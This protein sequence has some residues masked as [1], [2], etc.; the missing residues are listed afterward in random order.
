MLARL[1]SP[2]R[3]EQRDTVSLSQ[4]AHLWGPN[5][6]YGYTPVTVSTQSALGHAASSACIDVLATSVS[7]LPVDAVRIVGSIRRPVSPPPQLVTQ[8]SVLVELDSWLYQLVDSMLTDGNGFGLVVATDLAQRPTQIELLAP[9]TVTERELVKGVPQAKVDSDTHK[10]YPYGD[11]WHVPGKFVRAGSPFAES[12]LRR[13][14]ATIGAAIAA[15]DYGSRWFGD[16]GHPSGLIYSE[17]DLTPEEARAIKQSF[18][19]AVRGS[20]EP[21]V[22]GSGLRYEAVTGNPQESQFIDLLRFC[23]EEACRFWRV[24]PSMVYAAVS[25]QNVTYA[26]VAQADLHYLKHSLEGLLVRIENAMSRLLARPQRARFNRNAL[27]RSDATTRGDYLDKRLRN[28]SI[29][30][31]EYRT[32]EDEPPIDDSDFDEP[33]IPGGDN[34]PAQEDGNGPPRAN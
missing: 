34:T 22:F 13:A 23:I 10:L 8:P 1:F 5:Y 3:V 15:R 12:P 18:I 26:N 7:T 27:L 9:D 29:T 17:D 30:V 21:A 28:R 32:L 19:N 20:R 16:G 33:G 31:N 11:L 24:P 14:A 2:P 4:L 6:T 25:G